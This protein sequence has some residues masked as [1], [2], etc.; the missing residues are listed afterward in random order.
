MFIDEVIPEE[1]Q[2]KVN[3]EYNADFIDFMAG[4]ITKDG[5]K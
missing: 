5:G 4:I 3:K 1:Q 2:T